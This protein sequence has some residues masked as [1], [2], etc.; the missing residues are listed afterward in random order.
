MKSLCWIYIKFQ[1]Q[2]DMFATAIPYLTRYLTHAVHI[3]VWHPVTATSQ[4]K[5]H[6][7]HCTLFP[8]FKEISFYIQF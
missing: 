8:I 2:L 6:K 4:L 3:N 1:Y 5:L 7:I